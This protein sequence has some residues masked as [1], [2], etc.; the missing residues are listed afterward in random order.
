MSSFVRIAP[1]SVRMV[2]ANAFVATQ[3]G[4]ATTLNFVQLYRSVQRPGALVEWNRELGCGQVT[5]R[6][7]S[8]AV[9]QVWLVDRNTCALLKSAKQFAAEI[10]RGLQLAAIAYWFALV[11]QNAPVQVAAPAR[12]RGRKAAAK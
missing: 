3:R 7:A 6:S 8:G 10:N 1:T 11:C 2:S 4:K 9:Q 12:K 5:I